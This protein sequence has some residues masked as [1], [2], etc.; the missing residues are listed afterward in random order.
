MK[1]STFDLSPLKRSNAGTAIPP[2]SSPA[3]IRRSPATSPS[4]NG[5][6]VKQEAPTVEDIEE[7]DQGFD[8]TRYS[9]HRP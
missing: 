7:E 4:R 3:P 8:L 6:P 5:I 9:H 2:S 1:S